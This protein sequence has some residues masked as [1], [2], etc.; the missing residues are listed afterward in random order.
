MNL[1]ERNHLLQCPLLERTRAVIANV[2]VNRTHRTAGLLQRRIELRHPRH[3]GRVNIAVDREPCVHALR[4]PLCDGSPAIVAIAEVALHAVAAIVLEGAKERADLLVQ[5]G[6]YLDLAQAS[7]LTI[8][9]LSASQ[10]KNA[11]R[12]KRR[13]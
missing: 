7:L 1:P 4:D 5:L 12:W 10:P 6:F 3:K 9:V 2:N 8:F 11:D 13:Q